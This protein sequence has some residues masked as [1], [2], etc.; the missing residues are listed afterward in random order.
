MRSLI[1]EWVKSPVISAGNHPLIERYHKNLPRAWFSPCL[2]GAPFV[3]WQSPPMGT[4]L[5]LL[6][7]LAEIRRV[8]L[9]DTHPRA[10]PKYRFK[11]VSSVRRNSW[12]M[13]RGV[14]AFHC[15]INAPDLIE[16]D[17]HTHCFPYM[18]VR[19]GSFEGVIVK[20]ACKLGQ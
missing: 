12:R 1:G 4:Q 2:L 7:S 13:L 14:F 18:R 5:T 16:D 6:F 9:G 3:P 15:T 11:R 20:L 19:S 17:A 8:V 10:W